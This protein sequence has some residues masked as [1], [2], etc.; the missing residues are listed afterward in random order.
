MSAYWNPLPAV[1]RWSDGTN[2]AGKWDECNWRNVPGPFYAA[3]TDTCVTGRLVAPRNV[4]YD[5]GW[6]EFIYRQPTHPAEVSAVMEAAWSDPF[7]GYAVDGDNHW[8]V[9]AVRGWWRDRGRLREWV[10]ARLAEFADGTP[11]G[12]PDNQDTEGG[13][14]E[15]ANYVDGGL[16]R[17]LRGYLF[18]LDTGR[19]P[20]TGERLPA[21]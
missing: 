16:D 21:L 19:A 17:Y 18:W 6:Q 14:R 15:F 20:H 12:S 13:L 11:D 1:S 8:T 9:A 4:L 5:D 3:A 10:A 7:G 2:L